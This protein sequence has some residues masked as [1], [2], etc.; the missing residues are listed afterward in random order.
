M[1]VEKIFVLVYCHTIGS[2]V[3]DEHSATYYAHANLAQY[4]AAPCRWK[5]KVHYVILSSRVQTRF[6]SSML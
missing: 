4:L 2:V 1:R 3:E 5:A 6:T